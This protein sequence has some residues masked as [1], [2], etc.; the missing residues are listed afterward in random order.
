MRLLSAA[1]MAHYTTWFENARRL[2]TLTSEPKALSLE[3]AESAE[4]WG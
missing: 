4:G 3:I 2:R 1:Q